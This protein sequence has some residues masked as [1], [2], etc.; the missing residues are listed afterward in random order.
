NAAQLHHPSEM[1]AQEAGGILEGSQVEGDVLVG[2][3]AH[4]GNEDLR[5]GQIAADFCGGDSDH[6]NPRV[7]HLTLDQYRQLALHLIGHPLGTT[8]FFGHMNL[9]LHATSCYCTGAALGKCQ[10]GQTTSGPL[11]PLVACSLALVAGLQRACYLNPLEHLD[12]VASAHVVVVLHADT[13]LHAVPYFAD[14]ILEATQGF[15][16]A[17]VDDHVFTQYPD[18][19]VAVDRALD[20]HTTGHRTELRRTEHVTYFGNTEDL[21]A[22]IA[23]KHARQGLLDVFDDLVDHAVVAQIQAFGLDHLAR[24]GIGTDVEAED[25]GI[26]RQRQV[27]IGLGDTAHA[28]GYDLDLDFVVA[29]LVQRALQC[30]QR[31]AHVGLDDD[32]ERLLL[33]LAHVLE[34][35]LQ[36]GRLLTGQ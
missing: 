23:A 22:H 29:Q 13:A 6:A 10:A 11:G 32:I 21:L 2:G 28:T 33:A 5:M 8:V 31:T 12:P 18:R 25:H 14:V 7:A 16:L 3:F 1:D 36:L 30:L 34:H 15:Q 9:W 27:G 4:Q 35:V 20:D 17:F 24:R 26:G 19:A